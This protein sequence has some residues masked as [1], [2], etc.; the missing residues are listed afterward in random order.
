[1]S[2]LSGKI[3]RN[4]ANDKNGPGC[5]SDLRKGCKKELGIFPWNSK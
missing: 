2:D 4:W 3:D 5:I 1:M